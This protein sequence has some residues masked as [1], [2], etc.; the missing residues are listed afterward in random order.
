MLGENV[1]DLVPD[2][3]SDSYRALPGGSPANVAV[4]ASRLGM[5]TTMIARVADDAFGSRV[6]GRL[7]GA[8][9]LDG[10]LVDAGQPSSLAVAVP[11]A[12]GATEYTFWVEGTA[13]WQWA[14]SELPERVTAQALHVG[15]LAAY[16]E[17]GADVVARFVRREHAGGAVSISFDPNIRPS[18]G[19]SRAGLVRRTEELLPH[20]H[21]VKVSEEDLAHLYPDVPAERVAAGWLS[22]GR[23]LVVV[24]LGGTGAV[25]LNRAGHAEVAASPVRVV[26][27]VGAGDTFMAALLC[28]LDARNLLGGDRHDAIASLDPQQLAEI[29][30]FAARAAAVTCGR[31]G[32]DPPFR[33][34]LDGA[35]PTDRPVAAIAEK[36]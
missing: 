6:R 22:S 32:A 5:A 13:D 21:I 28:A 11:G 7:G 15:S 16:R 20:T 27:T 9:V 34:E 33:S 2:P 10:L 31:T 24:T 29:G 36:A 18:V 19:G 3:E 4:A 12:D 26:D 23:L 1:I 8:S 25:L 35:A 17:P 14:D 30:R